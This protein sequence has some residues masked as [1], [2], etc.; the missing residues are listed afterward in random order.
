M[1]QI[2]LKWQASSGLREEKLNSMKTVTIG[3]HPGCDIILGDPHVSRRHATI[4][5]SEDS[6]HIHNH[7]QT[8]PVIFNDRWSLTADMKADLQPG[9]TFTIGRVRM[10]VSVPLQVNGNGYGASEDTSD[11]QCLSCG[12]QM[13]DKRA[14]CPVCRVSIA[15]IETLLVPQEAH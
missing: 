10:K 15:Q 12:R 7:S 3:R 6:F 8:N 11:L 2:V 4:T 1:T 5:F 14:T 9:D 13:E